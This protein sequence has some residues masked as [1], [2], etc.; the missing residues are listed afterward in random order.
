MK[1]LITLVITLMT[2]VTLSASA[3]IPCGTTVNGYDVPKAV[4]S[5]IF[6]GDVTP[7]KNQKNVLYT[8]GN[9]NTSNTGPLE[10]TWTIGTPG[11]VPYTGFVPSEFR[12]NVDPNS[13]ATIT[14]GITTSSR[15]TGFLYTTQPTVAV[16]Y[17]T[18]GT[19]LGCYFKDSCGVYRELSGRTIKITC[20]AGNGGYVY[21]APAPVDTGRSIINANVQH[22]LQNMSFNLDSISGES[23]PYTNILMYE[24]SSNL[25]PLS[26]FSKLF[27]DG[28]YQQ[29]NQS[30]QPT[31]PVYI[32][33]GWSYYFPN[34][35]PLP[36]RVFRM[37]GGSGS[38]AWQTLPFTIGTVVPSTVSYPTLP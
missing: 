36:T 9:R 14:D 8:L 10:W 34:V 15:T 28:W 6:Y 4:T 33:Y 20:E 26:N 32:S 31:L 16:T 7:C 22:A 25:S 38:G 11:S 1:K 2:I 35:Y 21:V 5:P 17:K 29:M 37:T 30:P 19:Y 27:S 3:Q 23:K 13:G 12:W 24:K 18:K